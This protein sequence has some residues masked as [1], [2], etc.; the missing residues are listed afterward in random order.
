MTDSGGLQEEATHPR[1]RKPVLV[2]RG[3]T[4]R[5]EAVIYGFAK[6]VG[7]SPTLVSS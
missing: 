3:S 5:P 1:I 2:L 6:V 7:T 4:E